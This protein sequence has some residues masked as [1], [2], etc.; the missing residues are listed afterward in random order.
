MSKKSRKV[1]ETI[2]KLRREKLE[3]VKRNNFGKSEHEMHWLLGDASQPYCDCLE[4][5]K[6]GKL[7]SDY[8]LAED[9]AKE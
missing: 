9:T 5:M 2:L 7:I 8:N 4:A 6:R 3:L 1:A